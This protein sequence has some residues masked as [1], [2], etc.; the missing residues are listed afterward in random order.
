MGFAHEVQRKPVIHAKPSYQII[1]SLW[2]RVVLGGR[3]THVTSQGEATGAD[4]STVFFVKSDLAPLIYSRG[5]N[6][7]NKHVTMDY[8][9]QDDVGSMST[10]SGKQRADM[11]R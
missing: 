6:A 8:V 5:R 4:Y 9:R 10:P 7:A 11:G 1:S 3:H 2:S